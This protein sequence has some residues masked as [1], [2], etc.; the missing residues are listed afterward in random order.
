MRFYLKW[1]LFCA[2]C[3]FVAVINVTGQICPQ[4]AIPLYA[5]VTLS[6]E[7]RTAGTTATYI[8]DDGY[9]LFGQI[10]IVCGTDGKWSGELPYC[11]VN[12]AYGKPSN[13]SS[14]SR[15]GEANH[16]NDGDTTTLHENKFCSETKV[17]SSP[18]WQVDLLQPYEVRIV[19]VI[20][21]GCCGHQPI[22]DLEIR[23]GN[24]SSVQGN[25]LC[26][27]YPGTLDDGITKDFSCAYP[28]VGRYVYIQMV[29][30][31][32]SLSLCE[33]MVFTTQEFS[34]GRCGN[35]L[36]PLELTTFN[37]TCYE[38]Q[39][40][41]GGSF[42]NAEEYC[43][44]RGGLLLHN[45]ENLT[46]NF[47]AA[48]LER[49]K[50][51]IK[52]NLVWLG[53]RRD[54]GQGRKSKVWHW[55]NKQEVRE[56]LWAEDQ[57]NNYNG[58]Q[59][60]VVLDGGRKWLWN[61]VTCDLD[62]LPWVC[63]YLPS[64]CGSPD[65]KENTTITGKDF[66]LGREVK[67]MCPVGSMLIGNKIRKCASNGFWT[68][69]APTCKHINCN[70]L[71]D[72]PHGKILYKDS[73]TTFN[74]TALYVCNQNYT[75]TGNDIRFCE[76]NGLWS[77]KEPKCLVN[78]CPS[79]EVPS[80]GNIE[81]KGLRAN[82]TVKYT[83]NKGH[84]LIGNQNRTCQLGG[85]WT[86]DDPVCKFVD[87]GE[88]DPLKHGSYKLLDNVTTYLAKV[89][90]TCLE[91]YT[92]V[93]DNQRTCQ[94]TGLWSGIDPKCE[95][96]NCG[97]PETPL[98]SYFT[99]DEFTIHSKIE[100]HCESGHK[101]FG[102]PLRVCSKDGNWTGELPEC[103]F[104]DCGRVQPIL[105]GE[106]NYVNSTTF[107]NS[108]LTYSCSRGYRLIGGSRLRT[109]V[110]E[111]KWSGN[112]PKCEEVRCVPPEV[113]KNAT[114]IYGG[115]DRTSL[116]SFKI[117]ATVQYR[118]IPGHLVKGEP[119]RTCLPSGIW[120]GQ[121]PICVYVDCGLPLPVPHGRWL[122]PSNTTYY[123]NQVEY[124][125]DINY[126]L[127]GP[128]RRLC[129]ENASWSNIEPECQEVSC[130]EPEKKDNITVIEGKQF[131]VSSSVL[132]SCQYGYTLKGNGTRVCQSNGFWSGVVPYCELVDCDSPGVIFNGRGFLA[133][134][135]TTYG[136][137]VEYNCLPE[138][139]MVGDPV[140]RCTAE[141]KWSGKP[142]KCIDIIK[143]EG[144][145]R[146]DGQTS[147]EDFDMSK[148]IGIGVAVGT[149]ALLIVIIVIAIVC[150]KTRKVQ[151][152]KNTENVEVNR[153]EDKDRAAVMSYSR[154]SLETETA[155]TLNGNG[156]IRNNP[157]GLV[158]FS[159]GG[160]QP[161]YAN[162]T[163]NGQN[164]NASHGRNMNSAG[165]SN[166][167]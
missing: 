2:S 15:G 149:G 30:I 157:N 43:R 148:T 39:G 35:Q 79:L 74:A 37:R 125:C 42:Q 51:K 163:V 1:N 140:R 78:W 103:R 75:L 99:G 112:A 50:E 138:F 164:M 159:S 9:Q 153:V 136:S 120:S 83:C 97:E 46:Q 150:M 22:H 87:C 95:I 102:N 12:V 54:S 16:A 85:K 156:A 84:K 92:L 96:I 76:G 38:F 5:T 3:L 24:S 115:N 11:A 70:S 88:I 10:S 34:A 4:P 41:K 98:G 71:N 67:Y 108:I 72:I 124:Q 155:N 19:R 57:P 166:N 106:I 160:S 113:P 158:T 152:V 101:M 66:R 91:N 23:I 26:A 45:V 27:W 110:E 139:Q 82:D 77:G 137:V 121:P 63:Q 135:T 147:D 127:K 93:G 128:G 48:E 100:Y 123:G 62:Y 116:E 94:D 117:G 89:S 36:E 105:K 107:L 13:Q 53:V 132:Y 31:Q 61:D 65:R 161:I 129:L 29:G 154:L 14:T 59:N 86:G 126:E 32:G 69:N 90:Y 165:Q 49:R 119:L 145:G 20:T 81:V 47:I 141:G 118:C 134:G 122:L 144:A 162:V 104:I 7:N 18:W 114:V 64:S 25:R 56:F 143:N 68:G 80:N 60:C 151:K 142:P 131:V 109:C 73:R 130:G 17:E 146:S 133:N 33:V 111:G 44:A 8:C 40:Q 6:N 167:L 55:V 21:R 52:A 28:I 58:K